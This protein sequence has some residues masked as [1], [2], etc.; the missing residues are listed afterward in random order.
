LSNFSRL[1][2]LQGFALLAVVMQSQAAVA[3]AG[4]GATLPGSEP[5]PVVVAPAS[6]HEVV[7]PEFV[8]ALTTFESGRN[9]SNPVWSPDGKLVAFERSRGDKREIVISHLDGKLIK[10]IYFQLSGAEQNNKESQFLMPGIAEDPS[11][12]SGVSWAKDS[13]HLAFMSNGGEGN[14]DIYS[15]FLGGL[16][17]RLT[18]HREK[19][20]LADWSPTSNEVVFISGR[21]GKGDVYLLS[22]ETRLVTQLTSGEKSYLYPRWSPDGKKIALIYGSTEN[23]DVYVIDDLKKPAESLRALSSWRFD[24]LRPAWSPDGKRIAFYSNYNLDGEQKKWSLVVI[25]V[26][27]S[28]SEDGKSLEGGVVATDVIPDIEQ[29]PAWLADGSG[30]AYVKND[31]LEYNPIYIVNL[32]SRKSVQLKTDTKMNHDISC[33][34]NGMIAFRAQQDQWDQIFIAK[35]K[36]K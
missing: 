28:D 3:E 29:G 2:W 5:S 18:E 13:K 24:D 20:G 27:G 22:P 35:L 34:P 25:A 26:D 17:K 31:E 16:A 6:R 11:Y 33:G 8:H 19:D 15:Q 32:H 30:L 21:S 36:T 10:T 4:V 12:N 7:E 23:H 9:D 1:V 14:Y